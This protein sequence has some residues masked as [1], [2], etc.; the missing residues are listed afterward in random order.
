M[1]L[2]ELIGT[3]DGSVT[4]AIYADQLKNRTIILNGEIDESVIEKVFVPLFNFDRD[5]SNEPVTLILNSVGGS[6]YDSF[7]VTD[8]IENYHKPLTV[9]GTGCVLS[10]ALLLLMAGKNNPNVT[11]CAFPK[12]VGLLHAGSMNVSGTQ[13]QVRDITNF[14]RH[15]EEIVKK[16]VLQNTT[17]TEEEYENNYDRELYM[18]GYQL[19]EHGIVDKVLG[20]DKIP[21]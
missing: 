12:T 14:N 3:L 4:E 8:I 10:M 6:V 21:D 9:I 15:L 19:L 18:S 5:D 17:F 16:F 2:D 13:G 7:A 1:T 11:R 20:S